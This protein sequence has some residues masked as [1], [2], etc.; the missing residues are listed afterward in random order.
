M[1]QEFVRVKGKKYKKNR[2][3]YNELN[4]QHVKRQVLHRLPPKDDG[5][6]EIDREQG[7]AANYKKKSDLIQNKRNRNNGLPGN[8]DIDST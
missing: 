3:Q 2:N 6:K 1:I 5:I 4:S 7:D 8:G